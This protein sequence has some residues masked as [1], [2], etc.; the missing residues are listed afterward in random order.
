MLRAMDQVIPATLNP[1]SSSRERRQFSPNRVVGEGIRKTQPVH[2]LHQVQQIQ[3]QRST[4][5]GQN[6]R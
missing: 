3:R 6:Y 2:H 4:Q 1:S 5:I